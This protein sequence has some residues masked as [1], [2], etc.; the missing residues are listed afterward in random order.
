[1]D[2]KKVLISAGLEDKEAA[3]YLAALALGPST[4]SDIAK[5]SGL[6][7]PT[8]YFL[9]ERLKAAGFAGS[10]QN[11][12]TTFYSVISP[13]KVL[14][15]LTSR[16]AMLE[17]SLP[18]LENLY[19]SQLHRPKIQVF[20]G[21]EGI[22]EIYREIERYASK[23]GKEVLYFG[24]FAHYDQP[25]YQAIL[26]RWL[27]LMKHKGRESREIIDGKEAEATDYLKRAAQNK[28]PNQKIRIAPRG[29]KFAANENLIY[30]DTMALFSL[31][32]EVFA[33]RIESETIVSSMRQ[34]FELAWRQCR[35]YKKGAP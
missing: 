3:I 2:L 5:R 29:I 24:S 8:V 10:K 23:P 19:K 21:A 32:K 17:E 1:M 35:A 4:A 12:A 14:E 30:G 15:R 13:R 27:E 25:E 18:D 9:L 16:V 31:E 22:K 6:K 28:N 20:E 11:Q 33:V 26:D 7:R 34:M